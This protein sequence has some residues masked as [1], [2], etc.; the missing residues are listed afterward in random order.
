M[1]NPRLVLLAFLSFTSCKD[2]KVAEPQ[3]TDPEVNQVEDPQLVPTQAEPQATEPSTREFLAS[4]VPSGYVPIVGINGVGAG[5]NCDTPASPCSKSKSV[6]ESLDNASLR[7]THLQAKRHYEI[8]ASKLLEGVDCLVLRGGNDIDP[9]RFGEKP[10]SSITL[11]SPER[12]S[13]DLALVREALQRRMPVLGICLGAQE[14]NVVLGGDLIQD[15]PSE[16]EDEIDHRQEHSIQITSKTLTSEIYGESVTVHSNHHQSVDALGKGLRVS[17]L[18]SDGVIEAFEA[19]DRTEYPFLIGVQY[20]PEHKI[21]SEHDKL[22]TAFASACMEYARR[23][24]P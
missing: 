5:R 11:L 6:R 2:A 17:A 24:D 7:W 20:H 3:A 4:S 13:F 22:F 21:G 18:A 1:P 23:L 9:A 16:L 14:V 15:I 10:H 19:T 8:A 12:E